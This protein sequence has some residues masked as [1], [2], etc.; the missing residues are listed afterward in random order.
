[1]K[2][3]IRE[4]AKAD[5]NKINKLIRFT[6]LKLKHLKYE[7]KN[8]E[9]KLS[10]LFNDKINKPFIASNNEDYNYTYNSKSSLFL[11]V[12]RLG[13]NI[14]KIMS[15]LVKYTTLRRSLSTL[16]KDYVETIES[17]NMLNKLKNIKLEMNSKRR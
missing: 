16:H 3:M 14:D 9:R 12:S 11:M 10:K 5:M 2:D 4:F 13:E 17:L 1:M 8:L 6:E 15:D 7:R